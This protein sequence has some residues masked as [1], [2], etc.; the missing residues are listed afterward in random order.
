M[1]VTTASGTS[2]EV[3]RHSLVDGAAL[4]DLW[5]PPAEPIEPGDGFMLSA[6]CDKRFATCRDVFA[7]ARFDF[8]E[9]QSYPAMNTPVDSEAVKFVHALTGGNSTGKITFATSIAPIYQRTIVDFAQSSAMMHEISG[10]RFRLGI[11]IAH[12][13]SYVRMGVTPGKPLADTRSFIASS[14]SMKTLRLGFSS[15]SFMSL[16]RRA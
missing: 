6:G 4:I 10:G 5:R 3:K 14:P 12:G 9:L 8:A 11:G 13:P 1:G 15:Q 7:N 2:V 16:L